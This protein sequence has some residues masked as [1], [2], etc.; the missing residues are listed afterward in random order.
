MKAIAGS[1][2]VHA[3]AVVFAAHWLAEHAPQPGRTRYARGG[4]RRARRR[5]LGFSRG[6]RFDHRSG[7]RPATAQRVILVRLS[8]DVVLRESGFDKDPDIL[9]DLDDNAIQ[10]GAVQKL[11]RGHY[12]LQAELRFGRKEL[13]WSDIRSA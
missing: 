13:R 5:R 12:I 8:P 6:R 7:D 2:L 9:S 11:P 1:I 3:P 4:I 10:L